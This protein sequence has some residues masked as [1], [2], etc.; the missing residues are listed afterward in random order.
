MK[1]PLSLFRLFGPGRE[2]LGSFSR[3]AHAMKAMRQH[4]SS[5]GWHERPAYVGPGPDHNR[6]IHG[7]QVVPQRGPDYRW[8]DDEKHGKV[9][10]AI[11]PDEW[12]EWY[13][14]RREEGFA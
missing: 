11:K 12:L 8:V 7:D 6:V 13:S 4:N 2:N 1:A 5:L 14:A 10:Q 9:A 3:R